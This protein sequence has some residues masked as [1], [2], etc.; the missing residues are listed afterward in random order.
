MNIYAG[1]DHSGVVRLYI[2][3]EGELFSIHQ[4][5]WLEI[6]DALALE[7]GELARVILT[8]VTDWNE[9]VKDV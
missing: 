4:A 5:K 9:E 3:E 1:L 6:G 7:S 2:E 8:K